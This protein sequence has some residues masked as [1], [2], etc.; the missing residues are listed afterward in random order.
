MIDLKDTNVI[1]PTIVTAVVAVYGALL[2]TYNLYVS[3]RE[4]RRKVSITFSEGLLTYSS[5]VLDE[6]MLF[7]TI[8]NPG[9][10]S[11]SINAPYIKLPDNKTVVF[12]DPASNVSFPHELKE[13]KSCMLWTGRDN[14]AGML[15]QKGYAGQ[16]RLLAE[17][18]DETGEVYSSKK[19]WIMN[20][21]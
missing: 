6:V 9:F 21:K 19:A 15:L 13:G 8:S 10:R 11:V 4:K 5:G 20:L 3:L 12:P 16:I 7:I 17:V 14:L 18:K 2:S 1:W